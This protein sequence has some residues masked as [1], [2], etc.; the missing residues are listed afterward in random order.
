MANILSR[1]RQVAII[2]A[3]VEGNSI[4]S[5]A[6]MNSTPSLRTARSTSRW[7]LARLFV[8]AKS[9]SSIGTTFR[10]RPIRARAAWTPKP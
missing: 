9:S 5:V 2:R 1:D 10:P 6:R 7:R 8:M 4:R 3:L